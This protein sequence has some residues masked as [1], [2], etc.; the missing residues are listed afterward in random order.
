MSGDFEVRTAKPD[1]LDAILAIYPRAFPDED[2]SELVTELF[3]HE[4]VL[5]L[6]ALKNGQI[7]GHGAYARCASSAGSEGLALLG[8]LCVDVDHHKGGIGTALI[9]AGAEALSQAGFTEILV[10]GDHNYYGPRGFE[11]RSQVAAPYPLKPEWFE[12]WRSMA[13]GDKPRASGTLIPADPW[14]KPEHWV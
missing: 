8:P 1:E 4:A 3:R 13:L 10:L 5:D 9:K 14:M 6:V 12:S 7:V 2:L 11:V